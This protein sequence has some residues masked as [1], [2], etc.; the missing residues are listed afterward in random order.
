MD[1]QNIG[2]SKFYT[3][4]FLALVLLTVISTGL[5]QLNLGYLNVVFTVGLAV[6]SGA[7]VFTS[8]MRMKLDGSFARL[9]IAG[10]LALALLVFFIAFVG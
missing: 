3:L 5:S 7:I 9:L 10:L 2:T 4:I 6:V 8:F 1:N